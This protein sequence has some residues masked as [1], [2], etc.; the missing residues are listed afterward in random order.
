[1]RNRIEILRSH[2]DNLSD[3]SVDGGSCFIESHMLSVSNFAAMI[4]M[5]RGL[6]PEIATM[7]GLLHDIH[8]LLTGD[9]TEHAKQGSLLAEEILSKLNITTQEETELICTAVRY[10]SKK[11]SVHD[12]Y[13]ELIKDADVLSHCFYNISFP[14][15]EKDQARF[16]ALKKEFGLTGCSFS[17]SGDFQ[18]DEKD[19]RNENQDDAYPL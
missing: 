12:A 16:E 4:A 18:L 11:R 10:H 1:M 8:P 19:D 7:I 5:K 13:S 6:D 2:I 17:V 9:Y 14:A 15:L 3:D